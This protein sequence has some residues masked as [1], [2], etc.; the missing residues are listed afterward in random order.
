M[1]KLPMRR[2]KSY[3]PKN[4]W[5]N[6]TDLT[7][8]TKK[9]LGSQYINITMENG[10]T[11]QGF[12]QTIKHPRYWNLPD[13]ESEG[14]TIPEDTLSDQLKRLFHFPN[15]IKDLLMAKMIRVGRLLNSH[16]GRW[17]ENSKNYLPYFCQHCQYEHDIC[18]EQ[19][20]SCDAW[21]HFTQYTGTCHQCFNRNDEHIVNEFCLECLK[22]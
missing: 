14:I 17:M 3:D 10:S 16:T 13:S 21:D 18:H 11:F 5:I 20:Q 19:C 7:N 8:Q 9:L 15:Y 2:R 6:M 1:S 12:V 22:E 4:G